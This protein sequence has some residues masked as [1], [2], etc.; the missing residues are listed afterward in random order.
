MATDFTNLFASVKPL[1]KRGGRTGYIKGNAD[2]G[3][4]TI[5][6]NRASGENRYEIKIANL[7]NLNQ[8][9]AKALGL[10]DKT[11]SDRPNIAREYSPYLKALVEAG[12]E[13]LEDA[14]I[15]LG[16]PTDTKTFAERLEQIING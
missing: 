10:A 8:E 12:T 15:K 11:A 13:A 16:F 7:E 1:E 5:R 2:K 3:Y 14:K 4:A 9:V 6:I